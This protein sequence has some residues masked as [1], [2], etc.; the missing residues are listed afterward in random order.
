MSVDKIVIVIDDTAISK[1]LEQ[2]LKSS[3]YNVIIAPSNTQASLSLIEKELPALA[4]VSV[5]LE[6]EFSGIEL[7]KTVKDKFNIPVIII[8]A[9]K[10]PE[11]YSK[12]KK[13]NPVAY[14]TYPFEIENL[15]STI[16]IGITNHKLQEEIVDAHRKYEMAIRA[17]KSGVYEIDPAT[18]EIDGDESLAAIFGFTLKE[19]KER[20]WSSLMPID[21]YNK[22][23]AVLTDLLQGK[24]TSYNIEH[25][26]IKNDGTAVW[27]NSSGSL[28]KNI[29]GK[30][31]IVGT[32][33][34][35][36]DRK[37]AEQ[38]LKKY[39]E[40]LESL[41]SSKDKFFSIIS[42]DLRNPFNSLLGFSELLAN[43]I[44][45]LTEQEIKDSA[46]TLNRT[47]HNLF[48][49]LT[50]LLEWS[51]L[52]NGSFKIEKSEV[53]LS[54]VINYNLDAFSESIRSKDI[55]LM[56]ET[57]TEVKVFADRNMID[58]AVRNLISNAIKFSRSGGII[59]IGCAA[60]GKNAE[61]F[62]TD[63]GV[64]IPAEDQ[65]RLFK[66]E[67]QFSTEGTNN[68]KG[69]GF[70]LLLCKEMVEKNGGSIKFKSKK[71]EG[72]TFTITL[73]LIV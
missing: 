36:N 1:N 30:V 59:T 51:K 12:A 65:E 10:N 3:G 21:D 53:I 24:I 7:A 64:G 72:S 6:S 11:S 37:I 15:F 32:L 31:K 56:R 48:N 26:V 62:V 38:K 61:L 57:E 68:E 25:R 35:I 45:D 9:N 73:P 18:F 5:K 27:A 16:E 71:D 49:L 28:V 55:A 52:Q 66:I 17:G 41:N 70:G 14:F 63:S 69:T 43:N 2:K 44:E 29:K 67:K 20:G 39:S 13:V 58:S 40:E 42:H 23:V 50:N 19:V 4:V 46:K 47:A 34:D 60:N 22:K 8:C 33:T 54:E